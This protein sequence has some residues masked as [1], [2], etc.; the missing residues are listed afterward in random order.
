MYRLSVGRYIDR[1]IGRFTNR[2]LADISIDISVD[3]LTDISRS[4]YRPGVGRVSVNMSTN[5][6]AYIDRHIGR[7]EHKIHSHDPYYFSM[8]MKEKASKQVRSTRGGG[9]EESKASYSIPTP[10]SATL[11]SFQFYQVPYQAACVNVSR[12]AFFSLR[13]QKKTFFD[14]N[15]CGTKQI[16]M[17]FIV[18]C[19]FI[20]NE[21]SSLL[22]FPNIF[23]HCFCM[24]SEFTKVLDRKV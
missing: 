19:R 7:G 10:N 17:W 14:I 1:D 8:Q 13:S 16:K 6:S 9:G 4:I 12:N 15:I 21:Y 3:M 18:V 5:T 20:D 22:F 2:H 11:S 23:L 24:L